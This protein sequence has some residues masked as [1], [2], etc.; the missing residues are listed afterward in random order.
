[1]ARPVKL[2]DIEVVDEDLAKVLREKTPAQR[3]AMIGDAHRTARQLTAAGVRILHAE[4][5]EDRVQRE[6]TQ[7]LLHGAI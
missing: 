7:R 3:V 5:D 2:E 1:M 4:W 6:V